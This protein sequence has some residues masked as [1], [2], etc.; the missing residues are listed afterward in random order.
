MQELSTQKSRLLEQINDFKSRGKAFELELES[1]DDTIQTCQT[2]ITSIEVNIHTMDESIAELERNIMS[3]KSDIE[4]F[5][6]QKKELTVQLNTIQNERESLDS[7]LNE[8]NQSIEFSKKNIF[9]ERLKKNYS[10][11]FQKKKVKLIEKQIKL[12]LYKI[13]LKL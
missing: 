6:Q 9:I 10:F 7:S 8:L 4:N 13:K 2:K 1:M 5:E 3:E 12:N 11:C